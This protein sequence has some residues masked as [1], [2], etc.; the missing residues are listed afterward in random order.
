MG[1][2]GPNIYYMESPATFLILF[3]LLL[4]YEFNVGRAS[5]LSLIFGCLAFFHAQGYSALWRSLGQPFLTT[6]LLYWA[7]QFGALLLLSW[8]LW[9]RKAE[10]WRTIVFGTWFVLAGSAL[11][12]SHIVLRLEGFF[13]WVQVVEFIGVFVL[14]NGPPWLMIYWLRRAGYRPFQRESKP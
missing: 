1:S 14:V 12:S 5:L 8:L 6:R 2:I 4:A 11:L 10:P 9:R 3:I 13:H 7:F